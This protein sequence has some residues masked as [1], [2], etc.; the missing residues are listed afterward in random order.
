MSHKLIGGVF[1]SSND[2]SP[3]DNRASQHGTCLLGVFTHSIE[4]GTCTAV[5][6]VVDTQHS[7]HHDGS[8]LQVVEPHHVGDDEFG[9][10]GGGRAAPLLVVRC[11]ATQGLAPL[12]VILRLLQKESR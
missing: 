12:T 1:S 10:G 2:F 11:P 9:K 6:R 3:G 7:Q 8:S 5:R 4:R